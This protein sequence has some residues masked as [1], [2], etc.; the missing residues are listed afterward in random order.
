MSLA[1]RA[2]GEALQLIASGM[3]PN[4]GGPQASSAQKSI[5]IVRLRR[6]VRYFIRR[7]PFCAAK[8]PLPSTGQCLLL[9]G[10]CL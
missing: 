6:A 2:D 1:T 3:H 7:R 9:A 4:R 10:S 8:G 5:E